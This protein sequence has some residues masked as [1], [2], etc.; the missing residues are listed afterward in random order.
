MGD[1]ENWIEA[2]DNDCDRFDDIVNDYSDFWEAEDLI[3]GEAEG[4]VKNEK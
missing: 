2:L 4:G 3:E 1:D